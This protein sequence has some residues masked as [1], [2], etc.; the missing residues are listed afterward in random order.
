MSKKISK[1]EYAGMSSA[2]DAGYLRFCKKKKNA[3][4]KKCNRLHMMPNSQ[5]LYNQDYSN[6]NKTD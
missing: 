5:H 6:P 4:G 1:S 2:I 3:L